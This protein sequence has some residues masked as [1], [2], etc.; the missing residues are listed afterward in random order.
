MSME[1]HTS[2]P[3]M[4]GAGPVDV[5]EGPARGELARPMA[6]PYTVTAVRYP[7]RYPPS[8]P[9]RAVAVL[10]AGCGLLNESDS[11]HPL[12]CLA[13]PSRLQLH[14]SGAALSRFQFETE[15]FVRSQPDVAPG[16]R[17]ACPVRQDGPSRIKQASEA[18]QASPWSSVVL[19]VLRV[20]VFE[21]NQQARFVPGCHRTCPP[22]P[23]MVGEA[24][25]NIFN[26]EG[27]ENHGGARRGLCRLEHRFDPGLAVPRKCAFSP[28]AG[29]S[30]A[31]ASEQ[32]PRFQ[33]GRVSAERVTADFQHKG[34]VRARG[35]S[36]LRT[37]RP[38][39]LTLRQKRFL[40][41]GTSPSRS[42]T[43]RDAAQPRREIRTIPT[44]E[45]PPP[46]RYRSALYPTAA[47]A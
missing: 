20:K 47:G 25:K 40:T 18:A 37:L 3:V 28:A 43:V 10:D 7:G 35:Q 39:L 41:P 23:S 17:R 27:T 6:P 26:T 34:R 15:D 29:D 16:K 33:I 11:R 8:T 14:F 19:R 32:K 24:A 22:R 30:L 45:R 12:T 46:P 9:C 1:Q 42:N 13:G 44:I 21:N 4:V 5:K 36:P 38:A 2:L 31:T